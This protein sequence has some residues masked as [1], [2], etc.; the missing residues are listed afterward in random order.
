MNY[1]QATEILKDALARNQKPDG[2]LD[3]GWY[4]A[5]THKAEHA[6][7]DGP[8]TADE[9]EAISVYMRHHQ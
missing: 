3:Y 4:L 9:L 2:L 7:L 6:T 5:V 8:F 1:E